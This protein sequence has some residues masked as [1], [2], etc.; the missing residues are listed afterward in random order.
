[1]NKLQVIDQVTEYFSYGTAYS[2][3][4]W[5]PKNLSKIT[6][7]AGRKCYNS[8]DKI[9]ENTDVSF[10]KRT[11]KSV[12]L[13]VLAHGFIGIKLI[14][15][16]KDYGAFDETVALL[17]EEVFDHAK[18][19][20]IRADVK[21]KQI[22]IHF[23]IRAMI[24]LL[25]GVCKDLIESKVRIH[26]VFILTPLLLQIANRME[27]LKPLFDLLS[28]DILGDDVIKGDYDSIIWRDRIVNTCYNDEGAF[29]TSTAIGEIEIGSY[30]LEPYS[31]ETPINGITLDILNVSMEPC[32]LPKS[33]GY[34]I[35][36]PYPAKQASEDVLGS[37]TFM[38]KIPRIISQQELRH[39]E[40]VFTD[41]LMFEISAVSQMSQRY[42]S[43]E[44]M[45]CYT[46]DNIDRDKAYN[47]KVGNYNIEISVNELL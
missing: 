25:N 37:V 38:I 13:S 39:W 26:D 43:A 6:E 24:D 46:R 35:G 31:V 19:M 21:H 44:N 30:N 27:F 23:N 2:G 22:D 40:S 47:V 3:Y 7:Y 15:N 29:I 28:T 4:I 12:H 41:E 32:W 10:N 8:N 20:N 45:E 17:K 5:Y 36:H 33:N 14:V 11:M 42:V 9:G 1:M 18:L 16:E 34:V